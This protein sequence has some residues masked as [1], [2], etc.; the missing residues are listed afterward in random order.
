MF[1]F[2]VILVHCGVDMERNDLKQ[3]YEN[4]GIE[5]QAINED[6]AYHG[7]AN[8]FDEFSLKYINSGEGAQVHGWGIYFALNKNVAQAYK[9]T[10][11]NDWDKKYK[12]FNEE[13]R[14]WLKKINR[15][16]YEKTLQK[17]EDE[18]AE[19]E[20]E[21]ETVN[22]YWYSSSAVDSDDDFFNSPNRTKRDV[23]VAINYTK[24]KINFIKSLNNVPVESLADVSGVLFTVDIPSFDTM[25]DEQK[26]FDEQSTFVQTIIRKHIFNPNIFNIITYLG[27]T[28]FKDFYDKEAKYP[29]ENTI[30][31]SRREWNSCFEDI[32]KASKIGYT[33]YILN[34]S[35]QLYE[36]LKKGLNKALEYAKHDLEVAKEI[37]SKYIEYDEN[38]VK[39]LKYIDENMLKNICKKYDSFLNE[40]MN[41]ISGK[42]LYN[43]IVHSI[44]MSNNKS[45]GNPEAKTSMLLLKYGI[46]GIKY[47][48]NSDGNCVVIFNP[49]RVKIVGKE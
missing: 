1:T 17:A 30:T 47:Y 15:I 36:I 11:S 8:K 37:K 27:L 14:E 2:K 39:I 3:L 16:G 24:R 46:Q 13:Q 23:F 43:L 40:E 22:D 38:K 9:D 26:S 33:D 49:K 42:E 7:T 20:K 31:N 21:Y 4:D 29:D 18:L 12:S 32:Y 41:K 10:L 5:G 35:E 48:G 6:I 45:K 34:N 25:I 44:Y 28:V 19:L